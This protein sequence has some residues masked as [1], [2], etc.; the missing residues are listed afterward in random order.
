MIE[1]RRNPIAFGSFTP[2]ERARRSDCP[3]LSELEADPQI[4]ALA[5][6]T[7]TDTAVNEQIDSAAVE[8]QLGTR[9]P[10]D[11]KPFL[12]TYGAGGINGVVH[13]LRPDPVPVPVPVPDSD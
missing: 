3:D 8:R 10:A 2:T 1:I 4:V 11:Y 6:I 13:V 12:E 7:P 9:L 5:Q